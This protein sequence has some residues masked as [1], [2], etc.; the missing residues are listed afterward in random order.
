MSFYATQF[1]KTP[2]LTQKRELITT[3]KFSFTTPLPFGA[4]TTSS[5]TRLTATPFFTLEF[6]TKPKKPYRHFRMIGA[7][8]K[9]GAQVNLS[10]D[11]VG[12]L[13]KFDSW[14]LSML[15]IFFIYNSSSMILRL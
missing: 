6:R 13:L 11:S 1:G 9:V 15:L 7:M 8:E 10:F 4:N 3:A 5:F 14:E 2:Q 12:D